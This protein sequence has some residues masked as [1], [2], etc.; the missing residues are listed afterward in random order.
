M[1]T[2]F[3]VL[4]FVALLAALACAI[5]LIAWPVS[6]FAGWIFGLDTFQ[7]VALALGS[8]LVLAAFFAAVV[9]ERA[10]VPWHGLADWL[11]TTPEREA[12]GVVIDAAAPGDSHWFAP[13]LCDS[14]KPFA[15]CC[16]KR[17]FKKA[18]KGVAK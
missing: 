15:R 9:S 8:L 16:G 6:L 17:A 11:D 4:S 2:I 12:D 18:P 10:S 14:G 1:R 7:A 13:C 5:L 3:S